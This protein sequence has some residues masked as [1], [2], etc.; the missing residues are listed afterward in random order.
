MR[1]LLLAANAGLRKLPQ[2]VLLDSVYLQAGTFRKTNTVAVAT[3]TDPAASGNCYHLTEQV[4]DS[5][6]QSIFVYD[7]EIENGRQFIA[8]MN[9]SLDINPGDVITVGLE[10]VDRGV[11][12]Y[13]FN[14]EQTIRQNSASPANP[15][16]NI[17]G[18]ALGYFSAHTIQTR[19]IVAP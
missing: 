5:V 2:P 16:S 8:T 12:Q 19:S 10:C 1:T 4:N 18:G 3:F 15:Q 7:D 11:Y 9:R 13:Y 17:T 14:L 6:S